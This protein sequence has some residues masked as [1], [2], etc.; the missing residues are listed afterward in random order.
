MAKQEISL[1]PRAVNLI[2]EILSSGKRVEIVVVNKHLMIYEV[3]RSTRKYDVLI[4]E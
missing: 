4:S 1:S 3:P 2:N